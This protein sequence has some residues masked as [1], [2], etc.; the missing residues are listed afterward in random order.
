MK[1]L[2]ALSYEFFALLPKRL[3][4][5][6]IERVPAHPF[7]CYA[8]GHMVRNDLADVAVFAIPASNLVSPSHHGGPHRSCGSL[9]NGFPLVWPLTLGCL[10][11]VYLFKQLFDAAGLHVAS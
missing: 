9:R 5:V 3:S 10:F 4:I 6:G 2:K 8:D 7:A 11:L 1:T